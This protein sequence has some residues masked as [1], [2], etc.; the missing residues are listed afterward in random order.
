MVLVAAW[1]VRV[2]VTRTGVLVPGLDEE[3]ILAGQDPQGNGRPV[4][5]AP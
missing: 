2:Q 5:Q 1:L 3:P 4:V